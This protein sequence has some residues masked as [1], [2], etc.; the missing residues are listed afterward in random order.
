MKKKLSF[1][2]KKQSSLEIFRVSKF[3]D[4]IGTMKINEVFKE[5]TNLG[6]TKRNILSV[7]A[8]VYDTSGLSSADSSY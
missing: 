1:A 4:F 8:S 3:W 5:A 2:F 7:T 6:T